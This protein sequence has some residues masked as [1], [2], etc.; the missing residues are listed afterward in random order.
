M[1]PDEAWAVAAADEAAAEAIDPPTQAEGE[2]IVRR[3]GR[4][5][6]DALR[7]AAEKTSTEEK[8][9]GTAA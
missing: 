3:A 7:A 8:G 2:A 1:T 4:G 9:S 6:V 5:A